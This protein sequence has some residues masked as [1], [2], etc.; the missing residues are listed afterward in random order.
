MAE[1]YN[2]QQVNR[3]KAKLEQQVESKDVQ[4]VTETPLQVTND[5]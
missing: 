4:Y 2:E 3:A 1:K 5:K